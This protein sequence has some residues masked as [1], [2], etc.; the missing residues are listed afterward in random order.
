MMTYEDLQKA[1]ATIRTAQIKGKEYAEVNQRIKAFRMVF[2]MGFIKTEMLSNEDGVCVFRAEVGIG[3]TVIGTG[4]SYEREDSSFINSTSYIENCET[5]AVGRALGMA[6]FGIDT[7]VASYEE[8]QTAIN[9]Q[10]N[11]PNATEKQIEYIKKL[12]VDIP[13]MLEFYGISTIEELTKEQ[14][15]EIIQ[16]KKGNKNG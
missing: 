10:P 8:V 16:K 6:G 2:P 7:S 11:A 4:T 12:G 15:F 13:K 1:N 3:D 14:A 5:S 9:N